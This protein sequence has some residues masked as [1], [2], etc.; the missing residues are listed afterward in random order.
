MASAACAVD[1]AKSS[2]RANL[3]APLA[4]LELEPTDFLLGKLPA[5]TLPNFIS[6]PPIASITRSGEKVYVATTAPGWRAK[7]DA[8]LSRPQQQPPAAPTHVGVTF[9]RL[10]HP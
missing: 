9:W 5:K 7:L 10:R 2:H 4:R 1:S 8:F 3:C 6:N